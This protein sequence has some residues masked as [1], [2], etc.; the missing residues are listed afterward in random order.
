MVDRAACPYDCSQKGSS[1]EFEER[2]N[3][4]SVE[5]TVDNNHAMARAVLLIGADRSQNEALAELLARG[6]SNVSVESEATFERGR[7]RLASSLAFD[8]IV[9]DPEVSS[10]NTVDA[11]RGLKAA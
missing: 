2:R 10:L 9:L 4:N 5:E 11:E 8:V 3:P 1:Y 6:L 7:A